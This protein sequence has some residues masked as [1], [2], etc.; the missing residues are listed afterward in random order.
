M[1]RTGSLSIHPV[2]GLRLVPVDKSLLVIT[3]TLGAT[4]RIT[5]VLSPLCIVEEE[6]LTAGALGVPLVALARLGPVVLIVAG[7]AAALAP[8]T[9]A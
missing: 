2:A 4:F 9:L 3:D 1:I 5:A 8:V 6:P 7:R